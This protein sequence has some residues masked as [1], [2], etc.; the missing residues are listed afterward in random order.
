MEKTIAEQFALT[1]ERFSGKTALKFK[2]QGAYINV[3]FAELKNRVDI[4]AKAFLELGIAQGDKV[5]ILSENRTEWVRADLAALTLGAV[6]VP[7]HTTLSPKI[8]KHILNDSQARVILVAKQEQFN[9]LMLVINELPKLQTVIYIQLDQPVNNLGEKKLMS[10]D[11]VMELGEKSAK[12][13]EVKVSP[14]DVASIVYTSGT[15]ALPKGVMLS[16][17]NFLFNAEAAVKAV[18]VTAKDT[19]LS[20]LPLSHVLER[21]AG[22]YAP[23]ILRGCTIAYAENLKTLKQNLKEIKPT[24]LVSVPRIFEKIHDGIWDKINQGSQF[25]KKIFLWAL[26]Q[27]Q[28]RFLYRLA[29]V[30][31]F[32][33]IRSAF[34]GRFR[35]TISG[36]ATLNHKLAKFFD[37]IGIKIVEGYGLTETSPVVCVNRLE[38][39]KFGTVGQAL[40]GVE[41]KIAPDKEILVRGPLVMKGYHQNEKAT[42]EA[43]DA[44]G[45]FYTG[46]LGFL[47][48][49]GFLVIIGRKK[50]MISLSNGKIVWPE[51]LEVIL[52]DDRFINQAMVYGNNKSYVTALV[53]PDWPE[54]NLHLKEIGLVSR[55]PDQLVNDQNLKA[56]ILQRVEKINEQFADWEKVRKIA[57]AA[58][59]FSAERDEVTPSLKLRRN[60]IGEHYQKQIQGLY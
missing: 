54:V 53:V 39:I 37:K 46:D 7:I 35:F 18:P 56:Y 59:E 31:V 41:I 36:G 13:I 45:W 50:E 6:S 33:K 1:A 19:L 38:N 28:G 47:N 60:V 58:R 26:K 20:F 29:D 40:N 27:N 4:L 9:K 5:A 55:E 48:S 42:R 43:I 10:L 32:R 24:I 52:N 15:T 23:L 8:I 44:D 30:L 57:L 34:G 14:D 16:H 2:F 3:S 12:K 25:K 22:Y 11:E 51:Q 49:E 17:R 21:T